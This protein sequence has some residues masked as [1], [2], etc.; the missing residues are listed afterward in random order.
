M[1]VFFVLRGR[2]TSRKIIKNSRNT[3]ATEN[4]HRAK[5][6]KVLREGNIHTQCTIHCV[7]QCQRNHQNNIFAPYLLSSAVL[8]LVFPPP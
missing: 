5:K 2:E 7:I 1:F 3:K 4:K 6:I 8:F